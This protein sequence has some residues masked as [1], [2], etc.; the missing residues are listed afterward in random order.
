[1]KQVEVIAQSKQ[2]TQPHFKLSRLAFSSLLMAGVYCSGLAT[3]A[4][5]EVVPVS[6][7][8]LAINVFARA[9][10]NQNNAV[11]LAQDAYN[12]PLDYSLIDF[13]NTTLLSNLTDATAAEAGNPNA[14]DYNY[15]VN[16][17]RLTSTE[18]V[19][20][21][22]QISL[23][24]SFVN[25]GL[26]NTRVTA[27]DIENLETNGL[28]FSNDIIV[29]DILNANTLVGSAEAP[30]ITR[31][32]TNEAGD[33]LNYVTN[34]FVRRGFISLNGNTVE[35]PP[36]A[37]N[38]GGVSQ[39]YSVNQNLQVAGSSS[40]RASA[41]FLEAVESC[42]DDEER[43]DQAL[44]TCYQILKN[45]GLVTAAMDRRAT[46]WQ[47]DA[48]GQIISTTTFPLP[49]TPEAV[50]ETNPDTAFFNSAYAIN[51]AGIAV[52]ETHTFFF[53][54]E[55]KVSSAALYQNNETIEFIDKEDYFPSTALDINNNNIVIGTGTTQVN[56]TNRTKFYTYNVDTEELIF[57]EDFFP[58][59]ASVA[60]DINNNNMVVGEGEVEFANQGTRRKNAFLY[61]MNTQ[62]FTDLNDLV[63][64]D[65]PYS[66]VGANSI[67]DDNIILANALVNE[68]ARNPN[69]D[70]VVDSDGEPI[71]IDRVIAVRLNPIPNGVIEDCSSENN[72]SI[73][74]ERQGASI[75]LFSGGLLISV[76]LSKLL[77]WRRRQRI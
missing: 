47:L 33:V 12:P 7:N 71:M 24:Q 32:Y 54:R 30:Y 35:L 46:I 25:D 51:D 50:S 55:L 64:C 67:N 74:N 76:L 41:G 34:E 22:Q 40:V 38:L 60:R 15:L 65:S 53:D 21:S 48:Q 11:V 19:S 36:Q 18:N 13:T 4:T 49:F 29:N 62:T 42:D 23:Y 68:Q 77:F 5:Y 39:A 75:S 2:K 43:G 14:D 72:D 10:D 45:G 17:V 70:L 8:D 31:Q 37:T 56:G 6:T 58:G 59:S 28:S 52:G 44:D 63:A 26:N 57:P 66:I 16:L 61:D 27:F 1:M 9:L 69:G 73:N 20:S 3:A